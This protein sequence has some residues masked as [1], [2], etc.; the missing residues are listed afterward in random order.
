MGRVARGASVSTE[1]AVTTE[2]WASGAAPVAASARSAGCGGSEELASEGGRVPASTGGLGAA[3]APSSSI[4]RGA[5]RETNLV[6][7]IIRIA[8]A[9]ARESS[10]G[11]KV[12][13]PPSALSKPRRTMASTSDVLKTSRLAG[14]LAEAPS[15]KASAKSMDGQLEGGAVT[16]G[17]IAR[18]R[19]GGGW[20]KGSEDEPL[21][22]LS[23]FS[24]LSPM[25]PM[26]AKSTA[27]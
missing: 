22:P 26:S 24:P 5:L 16:S 7:E 3:A 6:T 15:E 19:G 10:V 18:P 17:G 23:P 1:D 12:T 8:N 2:A 9:A 21:S 20:P 25:S 13:P 27:R 11:G 14:L 4:E